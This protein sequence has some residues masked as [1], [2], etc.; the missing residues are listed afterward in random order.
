MDPARSIPALSTLL[1]VL[2]EAA[3]AAVVVVVVVVHEEVEV[4]PCNCLAIVTT[5]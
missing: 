1:V 3:A 5:P 4:P 2:V